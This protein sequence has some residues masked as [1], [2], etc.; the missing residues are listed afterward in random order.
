MPE[1]VVA[2]GGF[3]AVWT[4]AAAAR[5][6]QEAGLDAAALRI[7]VVAPNEDIVI[8]PRLY[9]AQPDEMR[10]ALRRVLE[11]IGVE[12]VRASVGRV[13]VG[14]GRVIAGGGHGTVMRLPFDRLIVA[15]GSCLVRP[16]E[17]PG[18]GLLHDVDT[19]DGAIR[20]DEH[21]HTLPSKPHA[22]GRYTAVV[23]GAGFVGLEL[24]TELVGR[25]REI[26][27]R[28]GAESEVRVVLVERESVVGPELGPGPRPVIEAALDELG[29]LRRLNSTVAGYNGAVVRLEDGT[30]IPA[31]TVVWTAGMQASPLTRTVPAP[32]DELGRL[33]VDR[34]MR[35]LGVETVFAAGD[36][37]SIEVAAGHRALQACQY[38]HQMGKHAGHNAV[39]D[40]LRLAL[41]EFSPDPYVTCVDLGDAGAV[42]TEGFDREVRATGDEAKA[43]KRK[44]NRQLIYPTIDDADAILRRADYLTGRRPV[45]QAAPLPR[46]TR[47]T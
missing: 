28:E 37:A 13:E 14:R 19:V 9:E 46:L 27:A 1:I 44:I 20:L 8:R 5:R 10:V 33:E 42:Y 39:S 23:V 21:L 34:H 36:T 16:G 43:I 32:R 3:A 12:H 29:V 35:V 40:V 25:M 41:V 45:S 30:A 22:L 38:A 15:T 31:A 24:A 2:G 18:A 47:A 6:R 11:P 17:L 4:A 7:T 26:A